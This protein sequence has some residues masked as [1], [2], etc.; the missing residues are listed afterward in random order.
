MTAVIEFPRRTPLRTAVAAE[1]RAL[2]GRYNVNQTKLAD[3]LGVTQTQVS[4]RLRG[5]IPFDVDE[6][7]VMAGYFHVS[8]TELVGGAANSPRPGGPAEGAEDAAAP[9]A[10]GGPRQIRTDDLRIK[11]P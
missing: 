10:E 3:V 6:L 7:D 1:V 2:M 8:V 4:K 5:L 11:S 9:A